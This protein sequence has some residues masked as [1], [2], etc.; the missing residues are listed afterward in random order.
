LEGAHDGYQ[1]AAGIIHRRRWQLNHRALIVEDQ[2]DGPP[3]GA[4]GYLH[5]H[6][7]VSA[8]TVD[9]QTVLLARGDSRLRLH[10]H[11][12]TLALAASTWHPEFN[13]SLPNTVVSATFQRS[14]VQLEL[15]LA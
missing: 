11:G 6:P 7:D 14:T 8:T 12:A 15:E 2:L 10:A 9:A 1:Q 13:R 5:L 3:A 4:T